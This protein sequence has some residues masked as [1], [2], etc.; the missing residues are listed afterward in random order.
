MKKATTSHLFKFYYKTD[1]SKECRE[2]EKSRPGT[3]LA[4]RQ[5]GAATMKQADGSQGK[6]AITHRIQQFHF[7]VL[8]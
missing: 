7:W 6:G 4:G 3:L 8:T 5:I 1:K 2:V